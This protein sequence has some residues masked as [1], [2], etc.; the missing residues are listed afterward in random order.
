MNVRWRK[1]YPLTYWFVILILKN[2]DLILAAEYHSPE[3][4]DWGL[5]GMGM[6]WPQWW[7]AVW[8]LAW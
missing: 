1:A 3:V 8:L 2:H 6:A 7:P 4:G 5:T